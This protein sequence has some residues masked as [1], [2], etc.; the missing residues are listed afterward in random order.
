MDKEYITGGEV[1]IADELRALFD[2]IKSEAMKLDTYVNDEQIGS[3]VENNFLN[4]N[5]IDKKYNNRLC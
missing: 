2:D 5:I 4:Y 3:F 1:M